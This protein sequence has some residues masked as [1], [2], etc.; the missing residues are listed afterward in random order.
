[1]KELSRTYKKVAVVNSCVP[2]ILGEDIRDILSEFNIIFVDS[3]GFTGDFESGYLSA[4]K[5]LPVSMGKD[6]EG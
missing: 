3:P 6:T 4:V 1:M 5:D 2:S